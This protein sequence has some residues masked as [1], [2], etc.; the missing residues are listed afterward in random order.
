[1]A[2]IQDL[3]IYLLDIDKFHYPQCLEGAYTSVL[4]TMYDANSLEMVQHVV[5]TKK[6]KG[7]FVPVMKQLNLKML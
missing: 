4:N 1:M 3:F 6:Q 2:N 7:H 5:L